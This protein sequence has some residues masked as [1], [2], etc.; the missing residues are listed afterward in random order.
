MIEPDARKELVAGRWPTDALGCHHCGL[1]SFFGQERDHIAELKNPLS[2]NV[3][4][5]Q[6]DHQADGIGS[7]LGRV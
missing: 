7:V 5:D 2:R 6:R 3:S 4:D 1:V